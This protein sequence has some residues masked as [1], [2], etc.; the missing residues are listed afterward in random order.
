MTEKKKIEKSDKIREREL[1]RAIL[2]TPHG[3]ELQAIWE[4]RL[5][6][7]KI[8]NPELSEAYCRYVGGQHSVYIDAIKSLENDT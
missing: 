4:K 2:A 7:V 6:R 3:K 5:T 8:F 1:W